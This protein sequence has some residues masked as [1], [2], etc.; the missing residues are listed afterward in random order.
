MLATRKIKATTFIEIVIGLGIISFIFIIIID[1]LFRIYRANT[2]VAVMTSVNG[3]LTFMEGSVSNLLKNAQVSSI[4]CPAST[5]DANSDGHNDKLLIEFTTLRPDNQQFR[6]IQL[7]NLTNP[8][9]GNPYNTI[10][11]YKY[12]ETADNFVL[13]TI[14]TDPDITVTSSDVFCT[15]TTEA[16]EQG[17]NLRSITL[18]TTWS[19]ILTKNVVFGLGENTPIVEDTYSYISVLVAN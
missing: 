5:I 7:N 16:P 19:S 6:L 2:F 4:T 10:A 13:Y 12:D 8:I 14:F 1:I 9:T 18:T 3:E 17:V 15:D 11:L